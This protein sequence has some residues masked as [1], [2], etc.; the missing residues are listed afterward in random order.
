MENYG[1]MEL[2]NAMGTYNLQQEVKKLF[3]GMGTFGW[4]S[5]WRE[6]NIERKRSRIGMVV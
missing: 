4:S 2:F 1:M 5:I 6:A 3:A